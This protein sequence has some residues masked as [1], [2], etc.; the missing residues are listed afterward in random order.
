M[1]DKLIAGAMQGMGGGQQANPLLALITSMLSSNSQ[2]GGLT[3]LVQQFQQA[4][5][6]QQ[7]SSW[8]STGQNLPINPE[9]LM[10]VFGQQNFQQMAG[11]IGMDPQQFGGQ[12]SQMLPQLIDQLTPQGQLPASGIED[13]LGALSKLMK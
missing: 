5:L 9:Q 12:L 2:F 13:A 4:G 7:M 1:L 3:G 10:Q 6:G 11:Q 8:I